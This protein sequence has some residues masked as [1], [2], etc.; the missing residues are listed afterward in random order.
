MEIKEQSDGVD[1]AG[2]CKSPSQSA[3][4]HAS[5]TENDLQVCLLLQDEA[6][7]ILYHVRYRLR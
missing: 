3:G 6:E 1:A 5:E 2:K 7:D 4:F